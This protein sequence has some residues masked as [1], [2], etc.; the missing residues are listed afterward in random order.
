M[1]TWLEQWY[2]HEVRAVIMFF[3]V[4]KMSAAEIN[5]LF[6]VYRNDVLESR[7]CG[8]MVRTLWN[9][10]VVR[11]AADLQWPVHQS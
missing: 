6:E 9:W 11:E 5:L 7:Q 4:R 8:K 1:V 10:T 3:S 2:K